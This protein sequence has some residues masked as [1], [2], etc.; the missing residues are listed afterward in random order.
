MVPIF[1]LLSFN[2]YSVVFL[3]MLSKNSKLLYPFAEHLSFNKT[4]QTLIFLKTLPLRK[5]SFNK[6]EY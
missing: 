5:E 3:K 1:G 4:N 6:N 2:N